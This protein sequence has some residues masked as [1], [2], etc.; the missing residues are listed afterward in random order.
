MNDLQKVIDPA[1]DVGHKNR[2]INVLHHIAL[3][4]ALGDTSGL[5][6]LD[7][8]C[9][10]KRFRDLFN[11]YLGVDIDPQ[12][13]PDVLAECNDLPLYMTGRFDI[14]LTVWMLQYQ[15]DLEECVDEIKG[16]LV[17]GGVFVMIEQISKGYDEVL[18]RSLFTYSMAFGKGPER[19]VPILK[20]GDLLV[21]IIRRGLVPE[22][23][24]PILARV[25]LKL[26]KYTREGV[27]TDYLMVFR[28]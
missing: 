27:Y 19:C 11:G 14:V 4:D 12:M 5:L 10:I 28:K 16:V 21:G 6:A 26:I 20:E 15:D 25:H 7:I 17:P 24:F 8:G 22:R 18:P 9:G 3:K 13:N 1:D 23:V 2:Y